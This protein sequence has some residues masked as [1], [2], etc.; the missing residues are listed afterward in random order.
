MTTNPTACPACG[1]PLPQTPP[2][3]SQ[4]TCAFCGWQVPLESEPAPRPPAESAEGYFAPP[5]LPPL[6]PEPTFTPVEPVLPAAPFEPFAAPEAPPPGPPP[7]AALPAVAPWLRSLGGCL[8]GCLSFVA[9]FFLCG[10][11]TFIFNWVRTGQMPQGSGLATLAV[12]STVVGL[13]VGLA[14]LLAIV[15]R[16]K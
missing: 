12:I 5:V 10:T 1:A 2:S 13:L 9:V 14:V 3:A 4:V 6:E 8:G 11:I 15:M 7:R 16:R